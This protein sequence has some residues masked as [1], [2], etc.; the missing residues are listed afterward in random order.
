MSGSGPGSASRMRVSGPRKAA[1]AGGILDGGGEADAA[2]AGRE[3]LQAGEAE[4][5]LVAAL[6]LGEG[7][8]L[9]DDDAGEGGEDRRGL[10]VGEHQGEG[11]GGGQQDVRRVDA[12]AGA[13]GGLGVAGA[14]LD[15]DGEVHLGEGGGEV[16]ADVGGERLQRRDVEG[17]QAGGRGGAELD[18]A[19]AGSRRGSCRRRSGRRGGWTGRRRGRG[20]RAGGGAGSSRGGRTSRRRARG[21]RSGPASRDRWRGSGDELRVELQRA[22]EG[23]GFE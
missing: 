18:E 17:V 22:I 1:R 16:A 2:E 19:R 14:V 21:G 15:A 11:F 20:G 12:L 13:G 3:G 4:G 23:Y 7:V 10:L 8:D 9:V 5:E 6:G